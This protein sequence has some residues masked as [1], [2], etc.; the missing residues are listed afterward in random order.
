MRLD[1]YRVVELFRKSFSNS[2]SDKEKEKLDDVLQNTYLKEAYDQLSDE[3]FVLDKF[4]EFDTYEY[5][6]A[7]N[8]LKTFQHRVR[9]HRWI[10]W[11]SSIAAILIM[12]FL[13][14]YPWEHQ[15]NVQKL[16]GVT[17]HIVP[18]GNNAA[19]LKLADGRTV[20]IGKQPLELEEGEGSIVKYENGRLSYSSGENRAIEDVYNE[21]IVPIGAECHILLDDG[22]EVWV[23]AGS[24]L[25]YP[26]VFRGE[27]RK[28]MFSGEAF[29]EV[30]KDSR[31]FIVSM[32]A[33][34][35]RVLGTSFGIRAYPGETDY[36]TLVTGKVCFQSKEDEKVILSPGEQAVL[37]LSGKLEKREVDVEEYVG[38]K[39]GLFI[40][41]NKALSEIMKILERWYG[42][43]VIFQDED[44][45]ELEYTG[46][47]ERYDSINAFLQLLEHL[48]E[49]HYEIKENTIILYK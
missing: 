41:K 12:G 23:N 2:L 4:R 29:F 30:K 27:Q 19:I 34:D 21:L 3:A 26:V 18:P 20:E 44:L 32:D 38:W 28:V 13:F 33:G 48:N 15:D 39:D 8:K 17:Q 31:P 25:R 49:I 42:V 24:R 37:H 1:L 40:F 16:A 7:F 45:K 22:T 10:A 11:G 43:D 47:L 36:T 46:N 9:I 14:F 35:V 6:E 5:R